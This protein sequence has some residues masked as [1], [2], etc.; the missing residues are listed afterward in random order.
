MSLR[1]TR[2]SIERALSGGADLSVAK[3][4]LLLGRFIKLRQSSSD[5]V[6]V[7]PELWVY[8]GPRA[9]YLLIPM[10]YCSCHDFLIRSVAQKTSNYCKHLV[11][12]E[13]A[14][15]EGRVSEIEVSPDEMLVVVREIL[16]YRFSQTLRRKLW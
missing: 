2:A 5:S 1:K 7:I 9:H 4:T 16:K 10:T 15:R 14:L 6:A 11:G 12:L 3:S 8:V 13:L